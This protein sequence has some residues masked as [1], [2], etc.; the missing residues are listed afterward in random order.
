MRIGDTIVAR[1]S[2]PGRSAR[3]LVR[4]SGPGAHAAIARL[5]EADADDPFERPTTRGDHA[6]GAHPARLRLWRG[7]SAA[8]LPV[9]ITRFT[10]PRSATGEDVAEVLLPGNPALVER[11]LDAIISIDPEAIRRAEPGEFTARAFLGGRLDLVQAEGVARLIAARSGADL[12]AAA[13]LASGE[14]GAR[15]ARWSDELGTLA[16]LTE[17]GI[18]FTD[19]E[20]VVPIAPGDLAARLVDLLGAIESLVEGAAPREHREQMRRLVLVGPPNAGKSTLFNALLG[21][22]RAVVS[23]VPGSTRDVIAET[24]D[25][26]RDVPGAGAVELCDMAGLDGAFSRALGAGSDGRSDATSSAVAQAAAR[27]AIAGADA[28]VLCDPAGGFEALASMLPREASR[29]QRLHVRTKADLV[30]DRGSGV[31]SLG[32]CALDGW[33]VGALRRAIADLACG[34]SASDVLPRHRAALAEA[35]V[36]IRDALGVIDPDARSLASPDL[37]ASAL[38]RALDAIGGISGRTTPDD[39]LGR[40]FAAFCVGK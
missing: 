9:L 39:I 13:R 12:E 3:A 36:A 32:V 16:A 22:E 21:R 2:P 27:V 14:A 30:L 6:P 24:L 18:D 11:L 7:S 25:L 33:H 15:I 40:V 17:A 19:Q 34:A 8:T 35:T 37:V 23:D 10:A 31:E 26:S 28:L 38:R 1:S 29:T 4:V 20:D 5:I